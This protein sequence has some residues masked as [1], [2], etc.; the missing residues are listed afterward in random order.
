MSTKI[1]LSTIFNLLLVL[2]LFISN[3]CRTTRL[4]YCISK[5]TKNIEIS[6]GIIHVDRKDTVRFWL[7][8]DGKILQS[9]PKKKTIAKLSE[10]DFCNLLFQINE[11]FLNTQAI[12]EV[13]DTLNFLEYKNPAFGFYSR[14][15]WNPGFKTKNSVLFRQLMDT[16]NVYVKKHI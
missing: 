6:W 14:A 12:N 4:P 13:G 1:S 7:K 3:G 9:Q 5:K 8:T 15:V 16:I 2:F 11:A 10:K